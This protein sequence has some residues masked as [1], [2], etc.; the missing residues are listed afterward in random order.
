MRSVVIADWGGTNEVLL[1]LG[2]APS[3]HPEPTGES[4]VEL[5]DTR[6]GEAGPGLRVIRNLGYHASYEDVEFECKF[7]SAA[8]W[9]AL[10][11]KRSVWPPKEV[12]IYIRYADS[13]ERRFLAI[14]AKQG[15]V[16]KRWTQNGDKLG[17][18]FKFHI[19]QEVFS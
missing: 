12:R 3:P 4:R 1:E 8:K 10:Q 11:A 13:P 2:E 19:L 17:V 6:A 7:V 16:P 14:F 15:M 18:K 5:F 9:A